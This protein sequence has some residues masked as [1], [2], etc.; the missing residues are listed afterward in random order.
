[1]ITIYEIRFIFY[2]KIH[3]LTHYENRKNTRN[4]KGTSFFSYLIHLSSKNK[5]E[6]S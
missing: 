3:Y 5:N 6:P 1:M 4:K 2:Q